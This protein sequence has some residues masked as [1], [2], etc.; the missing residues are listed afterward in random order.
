MPRAGT[1]HRF[2]SPTVHTSFSSALMLELGTR[3]LANQ[4]K[5]QIP[6]KTR[7]VNSKKAW[8]A[9]SLPAGTPGVGREYLVVEHDLGHNS[10]SLKKSFKPL[11][12][13]PYR[14]SVNT[15]FPVVQGVF[16]PNFPKMKTILIWDVS[17]QP[18]K[19]PHSK[20]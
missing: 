18:N 10:H 7:A 1:A 12:F 4:M 5:A 17:S 3:I 19:P 11:R 8:I 9:F 15:Q 14:V 2:Q 6:R 16:I 13:R 20:R